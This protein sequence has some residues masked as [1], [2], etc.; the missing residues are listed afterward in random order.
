MP[1]NTP[2]PERVKQ[3]AREIAA[4]RDAEPDGWLH[5]YERRKL[6]YAET[7]LGFNHEDNRAHGG[8]GNHSPVVTEDEV[9]R[10]ERALDD[11]V[12]AALPG[13]RERERLYCPFSPCDFWC[14]ADTAPHFESCPKCRGSYSFAHPRPR[15]AAPQA[16]A[17]TGER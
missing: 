5:E 1:N 12:L 6:A 17:D 2:T 3:I 7:V 8:S 14:Y 10:A 11:W 9:D 16:S 15:A 4:A 13:G